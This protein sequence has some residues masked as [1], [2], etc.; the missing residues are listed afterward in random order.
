MIYLLI[1]L[2]I[3]SI[4]AY[5]R[6]ALYSIAGALFIVR[7]LRL[8]DELTFLPQE[9]ESLQTCGMTFSRVLWLRRLLSSI[10]HE[11]AKL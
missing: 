4:F 10:P 9:N 8:F 2:V 3:S 11:L 6:T 7:T 5:V 1:F